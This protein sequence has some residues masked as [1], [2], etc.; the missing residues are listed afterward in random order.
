ML[1]FYNND[2]L[3]KEKMDNYYFITGIAYS[4]YKTNNYP[5]ALEWYKK[6]LE[7]YPNNQFAL[8]MIKLLSKI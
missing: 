5:E 4:F 2:S 6:S 3:R 1:S 7:I 8:K